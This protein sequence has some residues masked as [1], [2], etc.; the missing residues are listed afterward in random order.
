MLL[1]S[2]SLWIS[3]LCSIIKFCTLHDN[4]VLCGVLCGKNLFLLFSVVSRLHEGDSGESDILLTLHLYIP[5]APRRQRHAPPRP[6]AHLLAAVQAGRGH[7]RQDARRAQRQGRRHEGRRRHRAAA[8]DLLLGER[9][10]V[11]VIF[12]K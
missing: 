4:S 7:L 2:N 11:R 9:E 12:M 3:A 6:A 5:A 8:R 1:S 10:D